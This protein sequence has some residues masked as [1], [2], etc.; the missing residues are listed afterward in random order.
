MTAES[1][2]LSYVRRGQGEYRDNGYGSNVIGVTAGERGSRLPPRS[3]AAGRDSQMTV[4]RSRYRRQSPSGSVVRLLKGGSRAAKSRRVTIIRRSSTGRADSR[5]SISNPA[6]RGQ[7]RHA[8][9][10]PSGTFTGVWRYQHAR[11]KA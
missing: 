6:T 3:P 1:A 8:H 5:A 4:K 11:A 2:R 7:G 9:C 10:S